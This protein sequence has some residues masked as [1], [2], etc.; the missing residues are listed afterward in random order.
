MKL[1]ALAAGVL[2]L[3]ALSPLG[4][5]AAGTAPEAPE[6]LKINLLEDPYGVPRE[7][8]RFSWAFVDKDEGEKQTGYRVVFGKTKADMTAGRYLYDTGWIP[9]SGSTGIRMEGLSAKLEDNRLYYWSVQTKDKDGQAGALSAPQAFTTAVGAKWENKQGIWGNSGNAFVFLRSTF[10]AKSG[11]E[12]VVASVTAAS[13]EKSRQFVYD[14]YVNGTRAGVGPSRINK[15]D[16]YYNTY[17]I[18]DYVKSGNNAVG[19]ICYAEQFR[20]FLCQITVFYSDGTS[21]VV[22]NSGK[23]RGSWKALNANQIFGNNGINIGVGG[24]Y[25]AASQNMNGTLYPYGWSQTSYSDQSWSG[26]QAASSLDSAGT[27]TPYPSDNMTRDTVPA[28]SV[29]KLGNGSYVVDLGKEIVG[30]LKLSVHSPSQSQI[31][32]SYGEELNEDGT[33]RYR[34]RT[35]NVYRELWTLKAGS[36][37]LEDIGMKTFRYVQIDNCPAALSAGMVQGMAIRQEFSEKESSFESSNGTLNDIYGMTKY[38]I[39]ATNQDLYVD[40]QSRERSAYEGDVL[41]NMLS[42]Y[43]FE[44]DYSLAR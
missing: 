39:Q 22:V 29:K 40:S 5:R 44:D 30:S 33:V 17:D 8:L 11:I 37:E 38:T 3:A 12:K 42:G 21:E 26:A 15:G 19:A 16:L 31:T 43:S 13:P 28:V 10:Q 36:Q 2:F 14:F 6:N 4:V 23:N 1:K 18:T 41:I 25:Y 9:G 27:L 24:Y 7:D 20:S 35:G 34:M 32:V